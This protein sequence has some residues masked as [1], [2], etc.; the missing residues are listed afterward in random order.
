MP[1]VDDGI[2]KWLGENHEWL[3]RQGVWPT[4]LEEYALAHFIILA[5]FVSL[6]ACLDHI[7]HKVQL[8]LEP[9]EQFRR[10]R[11]SAFFREI[12]LKLWMR[13]QGELMV[14]GSLVLWIWLSHE[15]GLLDAISSFSLAWQVEH[16]SVDVN[17]IDEPLTNLPAY[18]G[19]ALSC[20]PRTPRDAT[21][22]LHV[23][24]DVLVALFVALP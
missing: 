7:V 23:L 17:P 3:A 9:P 19:W 21:T 24:Q 10:V 13:L 12:A 20:H 4:N 6:T 8:R 22:L 14:V 1:S 11:R 2:H 18:L 16:P 5:C 15:T